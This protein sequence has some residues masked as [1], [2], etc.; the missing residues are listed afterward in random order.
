MN[1]TCAVIVAAGSGR[2]MGAKENKVFLKIC[3]VPVLAHTLMKFQNCNV[4]DDIVVVTRECDIQI[5]KELVKEYD[6]GKIREI[7]VGGA[8][9]QQSVYNGLKCIEGRCGIVA[10]HDGARALIADEQIVETVEKAKKYGA[11]AVGVKCKDTLKSVD[12]NGFIIGTVDREYT[13][14]I[15]T[16]Q[17]FEYKTLYDVHKKALEDGTEATDDCALAEA[18]GVRICLVCGSYD[19]IKLTTPEDVAVAENILKRGVKL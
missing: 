6:I 15:Q 4:I 14:N 12:E 3:G 10:V 9:R 16:P 13:Y 2:R 7:V 5:C 18:C 19:N 8:T 11:A 17:V 1:R